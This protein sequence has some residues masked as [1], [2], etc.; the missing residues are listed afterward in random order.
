MRRLV[1]PDRPCSGSESDSGESL[2]Y[3]VRDFVLFCRDL[4][5][6]GM[7]GEVESEDDDVGFLSFVP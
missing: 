1:L 5:L 4:C 3:R 6:V 7:T 2:E